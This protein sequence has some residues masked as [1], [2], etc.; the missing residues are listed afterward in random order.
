MNSPHAWR[1]LVFTGLFSLLP[2]MG[3][4]VSGS[5]LAVSS[6]LASPSANSES[7]VNSNPLSA[8]AKFASETIAAGGTSEIII[9]LSLAES[10]RAY[11]DK[12]KLDIA[13]SDGTPP[14][15][16]VADFKVA[17][18]VEFMDTFT[19]KMKKG[20][21]EKASMRALVEVP[22]KFPLGKHTARF[23]LTYQACTTEHCLFPK[24][25]FIE[26]PFEVVSSRGVASVG[27]PPTDQG[28]IAQ[29]ET[30]TPAQASNEP[31]SEFQNALSKGM[32]P[33][34]LFIFVV[35]FV[36]SLTPCV[37]PM[38]PITLAVIGARSKEQ[39]KMKSFSLSVVYVFGIA[40]TYSI[41]GVAA[42]KTGALFGA[43]LSS[44]W[45]VT[46][47]AVVFVIMGLSMYGLFEIQPPAFIR[48]KFG[49][50]KTG[51]GYGGAMAAGLVAGVV[52]S[53][54]VGPVLVS[55]LAH[56]AKTQDMVLGFSLL[57]TFAL[58]MGML[59]IVIGTSSSL[60]GHLP[61]AGPWMDG[62]KF[63]FGTTMI[64]M[65]LYYIQPLYPVWLFRG[66]L[67]LAL[68]LIASAFGAFE[69]NDKLAGLGR[70]RKGAM[71]AAFVVGLVFTL[72]GVLERSGFS[73]ASGAAAVASN[74]YQK[75]DW[76]PYSD[77][78]LDEARKSGKPVLI[79]FYADWCGACIE[80]EKYTFTDER[81]RRLSEQYTLL[82]I[83]ATEDFPG[84]D[85]LK[86]R[87]EVMGLPTMIFYGTDG[88][89]RKDLTVTGFEDA[90][91]FLK[92]M[93]SAAAPKEE[94]L[95][96]F[97]Y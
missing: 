56:I 10:Y 27:A 37:Y 85:E 38:I 17:P 14:G 52:A 70:V 62:V 11:L 66:L 94:Q 19:K 46:G 76:Q 22:S 20:V 23:K 83:D 74:G 96:E 25:I 60:L 51:G 72:A 75:L 89:I 84:L 2:S 48:D 40:L 87:Y 49:T 28:L 77:A 45:V 4:F 69:P 7:K 61:K 68:I 82:K 79:D 54:C 24:S 29:T 15:V 8:D 86:T 58:G 36:T 35:G 81:I 47:I 90:D 21:E 12:F 39:S 6:S 65:A 78:S 50:A 26:A 53:P 57:F 32:L 92:R 71:L 41:L 5:F 34:L 3:G 91:A 31:T 64:A 67:G 95:V 30:R 9:D 80:L 13:E 42:A 43:A 59:F 88:E 1:S 97:E 16:K 18:I 33:A 44:I 73:L 63:F 55:V 93:Q